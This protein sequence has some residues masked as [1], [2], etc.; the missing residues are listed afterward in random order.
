M[1][2]DFRTVCLQIVYFFFSV[3]Q[4]V[5]TKYSFIGCVKS[6]RINAKIFDL[7]EKISTDVIKS[8]GIGERN[9]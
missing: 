9:F 5:G 1:H 7:R 4:L 2:C 8:S 6:L 3:I